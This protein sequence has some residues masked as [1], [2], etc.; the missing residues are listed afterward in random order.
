MPSAIEWL[1]FVAMGGFAATGH[2][3]IIK[4]YQ[5]LPASEL[6]PWLNA[7][8]VAASIFSVIFFNDV[9]GWPF[10]AGTAL[11]ILAGVYIW[12]YE[13]RF[14]RLAKAG[15]GAGAGAGAAD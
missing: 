14:K 10:I 3:F 12:S 4:A 6:S 9:L 2:F 13:R 11:I 1:K 7:Q 5:L 8:V 15:A